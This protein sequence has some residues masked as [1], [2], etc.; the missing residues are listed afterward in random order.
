MEILGAPVVDLEL[1][2][3]RPLAMVAVRLSDVLPDGKATRVTYG[4]LNLAHRDSHE[5]PERLEPG[6]RY[7]VQVRMNDVAQS[8]PPGHRLRWG[9]PGVFHEL[10]REDREG[11]PLRS[12]G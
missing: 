3:D 8:F 6:K 1:A 9:H 11:S 5:H 10:G 7:A 2:V 4:L 12:V